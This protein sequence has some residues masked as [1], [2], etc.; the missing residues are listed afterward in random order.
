MTK[1]QKPDRKKRNRSPNGHPTIGFLTGFREQFFH[2]MWCGIAD[3]ARERNINA[4]CFEGN[5]VYDPERFK[6]QANILYDLVDV[7]R[8]DGLVIWGLMCNLLDPDETRQFFERYRPLPIVSVAQ[9]MAGVTSVLADNYGGMR[10]AIEHLIEVH[11]CRRIAYIQCL[12][13]FQ[14]HEDRYRAYVDALAEHG[15][16]F[17]PARVVVPRDGMEMNRPDWG[18][19]SLRRLFDEQKADCDALASN[20]DYFV[21][22]LLPEL[23]ARGIRVP[24]D[25]ALVSFDDWEGSDCLT[26]PLTTVPY[27]LYELGRRA[28]ETLLA[29][30]AG[31]ETPEQVVVPARL[32]VR[33]SCGC[34]DPK[35]KQAV[36]GPV[37]R[38]ETAEP[39]EVILAAQRESIV[40]EMIRVAEN[41]VAGLTPDWAEQLL[42]GFAAALTTAEAGEAPARFLST[43]DGILRQVLAAEGDI[44]VWQ[45]VLST[46]RRQF[47]PYLSI[48]EYRDRAE[49]MWLQAQMMIVE[50]GQRV[51]AYRELQAE[52]RK[53][54]L[55]EIGT[56]LAT[57]F[58]VNDLG[59][60]LARELPHLGISRGYLSLYEAPQPYRYPQS[61]PQWSRLMLAYDQD[62]PAGS[63]R[64]ALEAGGRRFPSRQLVPEGIL[65]Q[66]GPYNLIVN[67]LYFQNEQIGFMSLDGGQRD[68]D[69]YE[70]LRAQISSALQGALLV[71]QVENHAVQLQ[72]AAE[73]SRAAISTLELSALLQQVVNLVQ[74]RFDLYYVGLFLVSSEPDRDRPDS[75]SAWAVLRAASGE[76]GAQMLEQ[77][78]RLAVGGESMIGQCIADHQPRIASDVG[79]EAVRFDNPLLPETH[80]EMALPLITREG[81][82]GALSVQSTERAAFGE[83][84]IAVFETLAGQLA[85]AIANAR[86]YE[87][88]QKAY[89]E[90][91]QQVRDRTEELKRE[92]EESARLQQEVIEAQQRAI[93]ELSTP[94]IPV[95]EGVIVM[96][97]IG[98]VDTLRARDVTRSLLAGIRTHGAKVVILDITGV[99]IVDSGVANY[100]NKTIQAARL[101]GARAIVTGISEAV[102]TTI[103]DLGIDWS[104]IETLAD[105]QTGLRAALRLPHAADMH[106]NWGNTK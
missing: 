5:Y 73:V 35:V 78:H 59:D 63:Q 83:A 47:L 27:P 44:E 18:Q 32:T 80:S 76:A 3:V 1:S 38:T 95:L 79:E 57:N 103:V 66:Q 36:A 14:E 99:P 46:L 6:A 74:E 85:N 43:L 77:G 88:I 16:P 69:V 65:P 49:D 22:R 40:A 58:D 101:K 94:I 10:E 8:L 53:R 4:I 68:G 70:M 48:D 42:D 45:Q 82:I 72:T 17:D 28:A 21:H 29:Q 37:T 61:P 26:P 7:E 90:V 12:T 75:R 50:V 71:E 60:I 33:Q 24:G 23:Q 15:L 13:N 31:Q 19:V 97:L 56:A 89:A 102:A 84:E 98:S 55:N 91:G 52:Q 86:V 39:F 30:M 104:G 2:L 51:Q 81:A 67:A 87:K 93:Q 92:Q 41:S 54:I 34:L 106:A 62:L 9:P 100:L 25:M 11:G 20:N 96:P 64:V 105:L